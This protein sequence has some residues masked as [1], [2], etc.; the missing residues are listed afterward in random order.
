MKKIIS[1]VLTTVVLFGW[2]V[3][4][5]RAIDEEAIKKSSNLHSFIDNSGIDAGYKFI[6][7][8]F[9]VYGVTYYKYLYEGEDEGISKWGQEFTGKN[10]IGDIIEAGSILE[11][12]VWPGFS[13]WGGKGRFLN[14]FADPQNNYKG[15][16]LGETDALLW[17][18]GSA[19][20]SNKYDYVSALRYFRQGFTSATPE[21]RKKFQAKMQKS[22]RLLVRSVQYSQGV[23]NV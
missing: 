5:H 20:G 2:E 16:W 7:E 12:A 10:N 22:Q 3:N 13:W 15:L 4:T 23:C 18:W 19:S 17:A 9:E 14:H 21:E 6:K 1:I 11:D 8:D